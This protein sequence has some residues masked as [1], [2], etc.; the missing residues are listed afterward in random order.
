MRK[1]ILIIL[2]LIVLIMIGQS[3]AL[4]GGELSWIIHYE[5]TT[6]EIPKDIKT[7]I[8]Y[9]YTCLTDYFN[10]DTDRKYAEC[11]ERT[12][13][14]DANQ[15]WSY[16][17]LFGHNYDW[18]SLANKTMYWNIDEVT[19]SYI[20]YIN[21]TIQERIGAR[22]DNRYLIFEDCN[23]MCGKV[24]DI[25]SCDSTRDGNGDG[26]LQSGE[27]GFTF[28]LNNINWHNIKIKS[29]SYWFNKLKG[30]IVK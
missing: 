14:N 9:E 25:V 5:N 4:V 20:D 15:T 17:L 12:T 18:G 27:S 29:D 21:T 3:I 8:T 11:F 10:I 24:G 26:I 7:P 2:M 13:F 23:I 28:N 19:G 30:C 1:V 6:V 16:N 22:K